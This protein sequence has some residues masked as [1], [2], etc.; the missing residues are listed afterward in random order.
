MPVMRPQ[1]TK[2]K[3]ANFGEFYRTATYLPMNSNELHIMMNMLAD[4]WQWQGCVTADNLN[5]LQTL[6]AKVADAANSDRSRHC[7]LKVFRAQI[8]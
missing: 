2:P 8:S 7:L 3:L 1:L 6:Y 5:A 4:Y